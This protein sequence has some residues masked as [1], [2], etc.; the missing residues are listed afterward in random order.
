MA[1]LDW[2][3]RWLGESAELAS[4]RQ[5]RTAL[6]ARRAHLAEASARWEARYVQARGEVMHAANLVRAA[7]RAVAAAY[8]PA[9]GECTKVR[10]RDAD[11]A[12]AFA[13]LLEQDMCLPAKSFTVYPCQECGRQPLDHK[14]RYWHVANARP[15]QRSSN[16]A[17]R[18][19]ERAARAREAASNG[20]LI[21]QRIPPEIV[22]RLRGQTTPADTPEASAG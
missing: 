19:A 4:L 10:L 22:A 14:A 8:E 17:V 11:E 5:Q 3:R 18:R 12:A 7:D 21:R 13:I 6:L 2:L 9:A 1:A 20:Q 16:P 15:S